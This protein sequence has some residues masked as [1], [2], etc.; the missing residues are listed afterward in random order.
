MELEA[1]LQEV[2]AEEG[3]SGRDGRSIRLVPGRWPGG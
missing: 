2:V 3:K 1:R